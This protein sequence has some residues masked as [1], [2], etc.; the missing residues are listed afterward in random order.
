MTVFDCAVCLNFDFPAVAVVVGSK[1][2]LAQGL[3][4]LSQRYGG[5][6]FQKAV[7]RCVWSGE[8]SLDASGD[9]VK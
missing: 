7:G 2:E 4:R 8:H 1:D 9:R 5:R 3:D 6:A